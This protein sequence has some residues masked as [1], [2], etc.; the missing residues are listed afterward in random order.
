MSKTIWIVGLLVV[1]FLYFR[2]SA[3]AAI[4]PVTVWD[5]IDGGAL[6]IDVRTEAE[7]ASGH[8]DEAINIEYE[9]TESLVKAI[10]DDKTKAVVL[11]CRTGRRSGIAAQA[12]LQKG[13]TNIV[14]GGGYVELRNA[15]KA[16]TNEP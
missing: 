16:N 9:Q 2:I 12:L 6:V 3:K 4:V 7:F 13:Y 5:M 1:A 8:L 14:N 10:G 11:Y 15:R